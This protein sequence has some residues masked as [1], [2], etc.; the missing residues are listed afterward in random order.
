MTSPVTQSADALITANAIKSE[1]RDLG[2]SRQVTNTGVRD[3]ARALGSSLGNAL[4]KYLGNVQHQYIEQKKLDAALRQ[5]EQT[6][7]NKVDAEAERTDW[8]LGIYGQDEGFEIA[9]AKAA[10]NSLR[11]AYLEEATS[12]D[13]YAAVAPEA[14]RERH[15]QRLQEML[16]KNPNNKMYRAAVTAQ[17]SE[18]SSRLAEK[19]AMANKA[20]NQLTSRANAD[21]HLRQ[22]F[23]MINVDMQ[24]V[25]TPE[26]FAEIRMRFES[27]IKGDVLGDNMHPVAKRAAV[28]DAIFSSIAQGNIGVYN[29]M[30]EFGYDKS[31]SGQEQAQLDSALKAYTQDWSYNIAT[32]FEEAELLALNSDMDLEAATQAWYKF[33]SELEA[34]LARSPETPQAE[35]IVARYFSASAG[36]RSQIDAVADRLA[37]AG[38]KKEYEKERMMKIRQALAN[39]G[40]PLGAQLLTEANDMGVIK[41]E[42]MVAAFDTNV[43][44]QV[45]RLTG[46]DPKDWTNDKA[47]HAIITNPKV[48]TIIGTTIGNSQVESE[49]VKRTIQHVIRG[50]ASPTMMNEHDEKPTPEL[51]VAVQSIAALVATKGKAAGY[52]NEDDRAVFEFL[53]RGVMSRSTIPMIQQDIEGFKENKSKMDAWALTWPTVDNKQGALDKTQYVSELLE[54]NGNGRPRGEQ[55]AKFMS[56]FKDG[57]VARGGDFKA[58]EDYLLDYAGGRNVTYRGTHIVGGKKLDE[59][60]SEITF[61]PVM[62]WLQNKKEVTGTTAF[63]GY[64]ELL[65]PPDKDGKRPQS[66]NDLESWNIKVADNGDGFIVH[67]PNFYKPWKVS[68]KTF[69]MWADIAKADRKKQE[70]IDRA[71]IDAQKRFWQGTPMG[72]NRL[73]RLM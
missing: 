62:E 18:L 5:G 53:Q 12:V 50:Y 58:A 38:L 40:S 45:M 65:I 10:E 25:R 30:K 3:G 39:P 26:D 61:A 4:G 73:H 66:F 70:E 69:K 42:E 20:Y 46:G 8:T 51:E 22:E 63:G 60:D 59:L 37:E 13:D 56:V 15:Q 48:A 29:A 71:T 43:S 6:G 24:D 27:V 36:K 7:V 34:L 1:S 72:G 49:L 32:A 67:S 28:N 17:W 33:D 11:S 19:Q 23:D 16:D 57:L 44:E 47:V 68:A 31:F 54:N 52:I 9:S 41:K 2:L 35:S 14:Y 21:I 64:M 55:L